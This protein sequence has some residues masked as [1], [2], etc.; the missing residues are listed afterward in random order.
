MINYQHFIFNTEIVSLIMQRYAKRMLLMKREENW[1]LFIV[2][3][4]KN[5]AFFRFGADVCRDE[6][7]AR[8][9]AVWKLIRGFL[10]QRPRKL[11]PVVLAARPAC[12]QESVLDTAAHS[13]PHTIVSDYHP[14]PGPADDP[15]YLL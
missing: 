10:S 11:R 2:T 13:A 3:L 7:R 6:R 1:F 14:D 5:Y 9:D 12:R 4:M 15:L 8:A